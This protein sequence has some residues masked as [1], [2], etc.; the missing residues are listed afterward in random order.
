MESKLSNNTYIQSINKHFFGID[1]TDEECEKIR[2]SLSD[3]LKENNELFVKYAYP[4]PFIAEDEFFFP[5]T[6]ILFI[7]TISKPNESTIITL[8]PTD[9]SLEKNND[10]HNLFAITDTDKFGTLKFKVQYNKNKLYILNPVFDG[11]ER[12]TASIISDELVITELGP[13][14]LL[15]PLIL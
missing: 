12:L 14:E 2:S 3:E 8:E 4:L 10:T 13:K 15:L 7:Q 11:N 1:I 5:N 9:I 6:V